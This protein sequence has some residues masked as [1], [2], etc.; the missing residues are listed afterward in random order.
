MMML[1]RRTIFAGVLA[2]CATPVFATEVS[3]VTPANAHA[4]QQAG[5]AILVDVREP[6]EWAEDGVAEGAELIAMRD[7]QLGA[8]LQALTGGD[9]DAPIALICRSGVRS[10]IVAAAMLR[11]GYTNVYS[12][13]GGMSGSSSAPGWRRSGLPLAPAK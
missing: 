2:L 9:K 5:E 10:N 8:K 12:V 4:K 3:L 1:S 13:Q 6:H 7:P 11:A